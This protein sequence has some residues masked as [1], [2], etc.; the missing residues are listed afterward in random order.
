MP[1]EKKAKKLELQNQ[2][3]SF[4]ETCE[5]KCLDQISKAKTAINKL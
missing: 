2:I 3:I 1:K 4:N 5:T